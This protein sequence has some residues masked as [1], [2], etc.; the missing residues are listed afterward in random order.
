MKELKESSGNFHKLLSHTHPPSRHK[1]LIKSICSLV[2]L[3]KLWNLNLKLCSEIHENSTKKNHEQYRY[4][5]GMK[6]TS[7][8]SPL[9]SSQFLFFN[10]KRNFHF[11][12]H[13]G[14]IINFLSNMSKHARKREHICLLSCMYIIKM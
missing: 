11:N 4:L 8:L 14:N 7:L 6:I 9:S 12:N 10:I 2:Q 1:K 3:L 5:I 13:R